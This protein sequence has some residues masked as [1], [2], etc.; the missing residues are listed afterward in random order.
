MTN[1]GAPGCTNRSTN[2]TVKR[3]FHRLPTEKRAVV[4]ILAVE[5]MSFTSSCVDILKSSQNQ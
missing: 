3:S 4:R 5:K 2:K 1:C